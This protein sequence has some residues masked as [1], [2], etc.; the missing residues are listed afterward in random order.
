MQGSSTTI[1][2]GSLKLRK[3]ACSSSDFAHS[4]IGLSADVVV[5][6]GSSAAEL[7][8]G[9]CQR[10]LLR[11]CYDSLDKMATYYLIKGMFSGRFAALLMFMLPWP[12]CI[13]FV[14]LMARGASPCQSVLAR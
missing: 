6:D 3:A 9:R 7:S 2:L 5:R 10:H 11:G 8:I 14:V 12:W 1:L 13:H 4:G